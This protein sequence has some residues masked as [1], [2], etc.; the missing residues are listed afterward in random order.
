VERVG[1]RDDLCFAALSMPCFGK[2]HVMFFKLAWVYAIQYTTVHESGSETVHYA[3][4]LKYDLV[5]YKE[6]T[7]VEGYGRSPPEHSMIYCTIYL[8]VVELFTRCRAS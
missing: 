5:Y 4:M 8:T 6:R 7:I 3:V 2:A 1:R